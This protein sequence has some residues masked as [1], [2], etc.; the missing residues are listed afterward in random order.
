[1][2]VCVYKKSYFVQFLGISTFLHQFDGIY[3]EQISLVM[4]MDNVYLI[5]IKEKIAQIEFKQQQRKE[6]VGC[7]YIKLKKIK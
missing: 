2:Y 1:M 5:R 3:T 4:Q 7:N 6:N